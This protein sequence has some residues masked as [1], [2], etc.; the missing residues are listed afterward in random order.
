MWANRKLHNRAFTL[1]ELLVVIAIIGILVALLLPAIQAARE[2]ARRSQCK[3]NLKNIGL[4]IAN[5]ESTFKVFPT[6]GARY[7]TPDFGLEQNVE[8]GK[9][10]G[11]SRNGLGW[12]YQILPFIE[13]SAA[14]QLTKTKDLER[15]V[16]QLYVCPSRR[17]ATT[18]YSR[19]F[20]CHHCPDGLCQRRAVYVYLA[21]S[22]D[23][24][25]P[26]DG[27][28][29]HASCVCSSG[30]VVLW[31]K[32]NNLSPPCN[33]RSAGQCALRRRDRPLP[34]GLEI[35]RRPASKS[36]FFAATFPGWSRSPTSP[37]ARA[38]RS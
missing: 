22:D 8:D 37:T 16:M 33:W 23:Q 15:V 32:C 20:Q 6:G 19:Q 5:F 25:R 24:V 13:E 27:R 30:Q 36:G 29:V 11:P 9:P 28:P 1:V 35:H 21:R 7:L 10:L 2:A 14:H 26:D 3:N 34:V 12:A 38:R 31:R 4:A 18:I 17:Q